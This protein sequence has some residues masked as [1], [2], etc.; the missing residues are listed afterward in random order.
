MYRK[1]LFIIISLQNKYSSR[2][3]IPINIVDLSP[4][5]RGNCWLIHGTNLGDKNM[6]DI[7]PLSQSTLIP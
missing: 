3:T 4:T 2:D 1:Y 7:F 5:G 6:T